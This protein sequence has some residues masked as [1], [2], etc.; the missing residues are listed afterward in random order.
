MNLYLDGTYKDAFRSKA[1]EDRCYPLKGTYRLKMGNVVSD[2]F[3]LRGFELSHNEVVF[4]NNKEAQVQFQKFPTWLSKLEL[5][6]KDKHGKTAGK[7]TVKETPATIPGNYTLQ[8]PY[9]LWYTVIFQEDAKCISIVDL[10]GEKHK[11]R[12]IE[13]QYKAIIEDP[14]KDNNTMILISFLGGACLL[15]SIVA[16]A[17]F[18]RHARTAEQTTTFLPCSHSNP[19]GR[20]NSV[21]SDTPL[22]PTAHG[23]EKQQIAPSVGDVLMVHAA[24]T[25][26]LIDFC[27]TL[28]D[29]ITKY[30]NRRQVLDIT[31]SSAERIE[32]PES[33]ML[34]VLSREDTTVLLVI[35]P[36]LA[37]LHKS[38]QSNGEGN[39]VAVQERTLVWD[40]LLRECLRYLQEH[41][42][43][44]YARLFIVAKSQGS[45]KKDNIRTLVP[46]KR[47][48][49]PHHRQNLLRA[50][51]SCHV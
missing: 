40:N 43:H 20:N 39:A 36:A 46:E 5:K 11:F 33:W 10:K 4:L 35:S 3:N 41:L 42:Q 26:E 44:N 24:D 18:L 28:K 17:I 6:M 47:F 19:E 30:C 14:P 9:H 50:L 27:Q 49:L 31:V 2:S 51:G 38:L 15:A 16:V 22:I 8:Q 25:Q 32:S 37:T 23:T 48:L 34:Q 29:D 7:V 1:T 12:S 21:S 45:L 13:Y